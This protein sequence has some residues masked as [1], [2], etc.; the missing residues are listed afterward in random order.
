MRLYPKNFENWN[1]DK[2]AP[3]NSDLER[4]TIAREQGASEDQNFEVKP[5]QS[6]TNFRSSL[7]ILTL[8]FLLISSA[9]SADFAYVTNVG[10][11]NIS[12]IDTGTR[13]VVATIPVGASGPNA[14]AVTANGAFA[15]VTDGGSSSVTVIDL[16]TRQ[17]VKQIGVGT[18]PVAVAI[19]PDGQFVYVTNFIANSVSIISTASNTV[20]KTISGFTF[21][22]GV[23][24]TTSGDL[25][26]VTNTGTS[27][28]SV[29]DTSTQT[30]IATVTLNGGSSP[31]GVAT[32][33]IGSNELVYVANSAAG[34]V[35]VINSA[36]N[37]IV[38]TIAVGSNPIQPA[39]VLTPG[40][41]LVYVTNGTGNS[42]SVINPFLN[43]VIATITT[44]SNTGGNAGTFDGNFV[45]VTNAGSNNVSIINTTTQSV[46][47]TVPVGT[48]PSSIAFGLIPASF[49]PPSGT[50]VA[51]RFLTQ[52]DLVNIITWNAPVGLIVPVGYRIYRDAA[53]TNLA[54]QVPAST[55][56]FEDHNRRKHVTYVY[57][58]VAFD[59]NGDT[60][61]MGSVTVGPS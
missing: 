11:N 59:A 44:G 8:L 24:F 19:S 45:Y 2:K 1:F 56:E 55:L 9:L 6:K 28:V 57:F 42:V 26:Y 39:N 32:A 27:T 21:P 17:V 22:R 18:G 30:V 37:T 50:Q 31:I 35:N 29:I 10:S 51:N 25:A 60:L 47:A 23:A 61:N 7:G 4:V 49:S 54:A 14:I 53:L 16:L 46:I 13:T 33:L 3:R 5:T 15:Y 36:T 52:T 58:L 43:T 12:V 41:D 20:V 38:A 40:G 34:N 48:S